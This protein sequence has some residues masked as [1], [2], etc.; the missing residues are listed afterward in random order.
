[1][2]Q[3]I[4]GGHT[5][6]FEYNSRN[7]IARITSTDPAFTPNDFA[8][9]ALGQRV[10]ITD[11]TGTT[12]YVWDG[13]RITHEHDGAGTLAQRYTYGESPIPGVSDLIDMQHF[14]GATNPHYAYHFG[15]AGGI[16]R[17]T[18]AAE[19]IA[20]TLEFSP[21]GRI[22]LDTGSAPNRFGFPA[23]YLGL[24]DVSGF[25]LSPSRC[26]DGRLGRFGSR[27]GLPWRLHRTGVLSAYGSARCAPLD[28]VDPSGFRI[29]VYPSGQVTN[30]GSFV[31][32]AFQVLVDNC[33]EL[34]A[35]PS[36]V[37][38]RLPATLGPEP[39]GPKYVKQV[40][41]WE[42]KYRN[43]RPCQAPF[44]AAWCRLKAAIDSGG[45]IRIYFRP[46]D[47]GVPLGQ[48]KVAAA[49]ETQMGTTLFRGP[50]ADVAIDLRVY[51]NYT[52]W[53][54]GQT[55]QVVE[56]PWQIALWHE[57]IGHGGRHIAGLGGEHVKGGKSA[58]PMH[59]VENE[60]RAAWNATHPA[61]QVG[62][63]LPQRDDRLDF[64][65]RPRRIRIG[66]R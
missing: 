12:Y 56:T 28:T 60:A 47:P 7:L 40:V 51:G 46:H 13:I 27:D 35:E 36:T 14:D 26:Y 61:Q 9:N 20:Q 39:G 2:S 6:Y 41:E 45:R 29:L 22:V 10:R 50:W 53:V 58:D 5:T 43:E 11:S 30:A 18:D 59:A 62:M 15:P 19:A 3:T 44:Q 54:S 8:Y 17:L 49:G 34:Y 24:P 21:N 16:Y 66:G 23:T 31:T 65:P 64:K 42:M 1:M 57:A 37:R 52:V 38:V 48:Q 33:A 32:G 4:A 63:R 55:G 25:S